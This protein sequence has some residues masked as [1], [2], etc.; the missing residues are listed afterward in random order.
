MKKYNVAFTKKI[1]IDGLGDK[2]IWHSADEI[3]LV[4][5][6]NGKNIVKNQA[7]A[8]ILWSDEGLFVL[9]EV[10][11]EH[12]WGTYK[13]DDDPIYKEE[14]VEIFI[15]KGKNVPKKY[16]ELQFSPLGIKFDAKVSNPMPTGRQA[17]GN[18][19]NEKFKVDALWNC[20]E[21]RHK[22][23][24]MR[25]KTELQDRR[26]LSVAQAFPSGHHKIIS[27]IWIVE[28]FV[29]WKSIGVKNVKA[30]DIFRVNL[31]RIDGFP[32]QNSF[33]AWQ[34]TLKSPAD[35]HV[36]NKFGYVILNQ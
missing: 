13:N 32:K 7:K 3:I 5:A 34:P 23:A 36:P 19:K 11:D 27:G 35:F 22:T 28:A 10:E 12:I 15:A 4:N 1:A 31:F 18:R 14:A 17:T 8:K 20:E 30:G 2:K 9:W 6:V 25:V 26:K 29:P 16:F 21:L 24:I 33:Q